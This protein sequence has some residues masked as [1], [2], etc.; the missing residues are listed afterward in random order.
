VRIPKAGSKPS[1]DDNFRERL[2]QIVTTWSLGDDSQ[3]LPADIAPRAL[4]VG[5]RRWTL[6]DEVEPALLSPVHW[7]RRFIMALWK[8]CH[9]VPVPHSQALGM[10]YEVVRMRQVDPNDR[11]CR[12]REL[13]SSDLERAAGQRRNRLQGLAS[14]ALDYGTYVGEWREELEE[15]EEQMERERWVGEMGREIGHIADES[16]VQDGSIMGDMHI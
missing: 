3:I 7:S 1:K 2:R 5:N 4:V 6:D 16:S 14:E 13:L 12:V 15:L 9:E 11:Q 8:F 10:L